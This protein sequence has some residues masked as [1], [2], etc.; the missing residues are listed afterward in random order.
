VGRGIGPALEARDVLAVLRRTADAPPDL[1]ERALQLAGVL[2]EFCHSAPPG[3]GYAIAA[4]LLDSG[5]ALGKFLAIC[6]A[7]GGF[8]EPRRAPFT[9]V[10]LA[11]RAG[12]IVEVENRRLARIAKLAGAPQAPAAG[13]DL[14][15]ACRSRV[16]TGAPLFTVHAQSPGELQCALDALA[17]SPEIFTIDP[18]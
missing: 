11:E 13:I 16:E 5:Q 3:D 7:Q 14:H 12:R 10:V 8:R 17:S 15:V 1:R 6:E 4:K 9:H 2:L 18:E